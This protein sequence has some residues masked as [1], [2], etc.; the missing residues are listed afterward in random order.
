MADL[1]REAAPQPGDDDPPLQ[2]GACATGQGRCPSG[3]GSTGQICEHGQEGGQCH[4]D[5]KKKCTAAHL[6]TW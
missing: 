4:D 5:V 2:G 1:L 3:A 6:D